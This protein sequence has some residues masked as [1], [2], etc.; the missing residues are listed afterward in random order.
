MY[1]YMYI[2]MIHKLACK[3][4]SVVLINCTTISQY[5]DFKLID[6]TIEQCVYFSGILKI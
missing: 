4:K 6:W 1:I 2:Y 3:N 5:S